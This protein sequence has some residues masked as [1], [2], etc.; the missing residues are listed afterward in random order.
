M[1]ILK[2]YGIFLLLSL[3]LWGGEAKGSIEKSVR[4]YNE[5]IIIAGKTGKTDAVKPFVSD[6]IATKT[7]LWIMAWHDDNL[8]MDAKLLKLDLKKTI[9]DRNRSRVITNEK[10]SYQYDHATKKG[11]Y[12]KKW[13]EYQMEY[14]L[15]LHHGK[16]IIDDIKVLSEKSRSVDNAK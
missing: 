2:G 3:S 9:V 10:W 8:F 12:P 16:W 14:S 5:A 7:H 4:L 1:S 6:K 11:Y 15:F 13:I